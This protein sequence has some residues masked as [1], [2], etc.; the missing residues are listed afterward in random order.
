MRTALSVLA[1]LIVGIVGGWQL[2]K[3]MQQGP[4][5]A[6]IFLL[7]DQLDTEL[8]YLS[9]QGTWRGEGLANK[10]N[11]TSIL[12]DPAAKTCETVQA[13]VLELPSF[14]PAIDVDN[15]TYKITKLDSE[16]LIA[17]DVPLLG[18]V[19]Q[20]LLFDR[21]AKRVTFVRTKISQKE[22]C[23]PVQSEPVTLFL[24]DPF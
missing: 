10:V 19:R 14:G 3:A 12:C 1:A 17:E 24:G 23:A 6:R 7:T 2:H 13:D 20:T 21:V 16:S 5:A 9:A 8:P 4:R 22:E 15:A 18:C 11:T